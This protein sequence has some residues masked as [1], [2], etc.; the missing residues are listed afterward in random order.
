MTADRDRAIADRL[1]AMIR[2]R[3]G[4]TSSQWHVGGTAAIMRKGQFE[5]INPLNWPL[6]VCPRQD[7]NLRHPL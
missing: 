2:Q 5:G 6:V 4:D 7:S 1:G 3:Q